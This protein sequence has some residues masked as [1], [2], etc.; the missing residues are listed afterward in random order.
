MRVDTGADAAASAPAESGSD[1]TA[2][3]RDLVVKAQRS[4]NSAA[5]V[6]EQDAVAEG[7]ETFAVRLSNPGGGT[8]LPGGAPSSVPGG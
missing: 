7:D 2:L 3:N 5:I 1:Y 4:A 8:G 6:I